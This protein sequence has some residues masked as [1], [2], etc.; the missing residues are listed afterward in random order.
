MKVG[1]RSHHPLM[2]LASGG[3]LLTL[4]EDFRAGGALVMMDDRGISSKLE[5]DRKFKNLY[6]NIFVFMNDH[7]TFFCS[8]KISV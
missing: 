6:V 8:H 7:L 5:I 1:E 3:K 2:A 4:G